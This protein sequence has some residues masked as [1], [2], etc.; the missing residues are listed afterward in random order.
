MNEPRKSRARTIR[1]GILSTLAG[2][3]ILLVLLELGLRFLPVGTG[4]RAVEVNENNPVF[5]FT[6]NREYI[7]SKDWNFSIVN[8]GR[9]NKNGFVNDLDYDETLVAPPLIAVI[10]DNFVVGAMVPYQDTLQGR[11]ARRLGDR[12]RVYSFAAGG[13]PLSQYLAYAEHAG[14]TYAPEAMTFVI[15]NNTCNDNLLDHK[16]KPGFHYFVEDASGELALTRIDFK[17]SLGMRILRKVALVRY[18]VMNLNLRARISGLLAV[19]SPNELQA[20]EHAADTPHNVEPERVVDLKR[21][22]DGFLD[23]LPTRSGLPV[24][25]HLIVLDGMRPYLYSPGG[26]AV[27]AGSYHDLARRHFLQAAQHRGYEI[28]DMQPLFLTQYQQ[29]GLRFEFPTDEHWN[30]HGHRAAADAIAS[31]RTYARA[32]GTPE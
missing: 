7:W 1:F 20:E 13:A 31:S 29:D 32:F 19:W 5:S 10:G 22:I 27:A 30:G 9:V 21:A 26:L 25:R 11:L 12:G 4:L 2:L 14:Q 15:T 6:P 3:A 17:P 23:Q 8:K 24:S 16:A 18:A 28:I